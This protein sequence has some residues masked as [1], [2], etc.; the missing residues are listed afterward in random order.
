MANEADRA[1]R[2]VTLHLQQALARR[3][4]EG[5]PDTGACLYCDQPTPPGRRWCNADCRDDWEAECRRK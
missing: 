3:A 5:P 2:A 4:P 1:D